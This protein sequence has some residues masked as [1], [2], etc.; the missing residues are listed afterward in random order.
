MSL[1]DVPH[2]LQL[3]NRRGIRVGINP[4]GATWTSCQIPVAGGL[5]EILLGSRNLATML[6]G[7]GYLG[8]TIGRYAGRIAQGRFDDHQLDIN[9]PPHCLHGG[10]GGFSRRLWQP[11]PSLTDA[12][13]VTLRLSSP[14]GDQGFPGTLDVQ[15]SFRLDDDDSFT[16]SLAALSDAATPCNLTN[17]AY[18]N[19]NGGNGDDGLNQLLRVHAQRYQPVGAD[20]IPDAPPAPVAGTGFDFQAARLLSTDYLRDAQQQQVGG[21]DHSFLLDNDGA[22][23]LAAELQSADGQVGLRLHTNQPAL[24]LYSGNFLAGI[25]KRDGSAHANNAGIALEPQ[26]PPDSP[27]RGEGIL[28]PGEVYLHTTR[29]EFLVPGGLPDA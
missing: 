18:F 19:L 4:L 7:D 5:R 10:Q 25:E 28:H 3:V 16:I 24:H 29:I 20:G 26:C 15:V 12:Q 8:A 23:A 11:V 14:D 17:H 6:A 1:V 27:N 2:D 21:Y 9:Q 22:L 13:Q